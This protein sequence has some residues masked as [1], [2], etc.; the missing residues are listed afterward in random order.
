[1]HQQGIIGYHARKNGV[2]IWIFINRALSSIKKLDQQKNLR[3]VPASTSFARTS[4]LGTPFKINYVNLDIL[5]K[6]NPHAPK[7][8]AESQ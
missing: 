4:E 6:D 8:G 1:M 2:G 5:D 3:S 7:T